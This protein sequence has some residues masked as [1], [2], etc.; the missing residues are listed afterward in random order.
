MLTEGSFPFDLKFD[1]EPKVSR[2]DHLTYAIGDIHG[3][4]D[5]FQKMIA[6]I[7]HD[8]AQLNARPRVVLLGDYIDRGPESRR[9]LDTILALQDQVWC[10]LVV[11]M[12]NHEKTL[13]NF[14]H[15]AAYGP[16]WIEFGALSTFHAYGVPIAKPPAN[17]EEW[18]AVRLE[19]MQAMPTDHLLL[20]ASMPVRFTAGD[21]LFVHAGVDPVVELSEQGPDTLLWIRSAFLTVEKSCDYVVVH[22]HT[23]DTK[24]ANLRWRI[25]VD[26][27]AYATGVLTAVRLKGET[28]DLIQVK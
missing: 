3:R 26:T 7:K 10:E 20:Y 15:D 21:Y 28:R 18:E 11:L 9:V 13:L 16:R 22:G 8:S 1:D 24:P 27:G 6:L 12:G 25:G 5:L 2:I 23:A 17:E 4:L 19:L 14:L